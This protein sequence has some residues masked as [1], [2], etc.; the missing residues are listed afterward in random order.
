MKVHK[1]S[2]SILEKAYTYQKTMIMAKNKLKKRLKKFLIDRKE[3]QIKPKK[4]PL[5]CLSRI[6]SA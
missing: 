1:W 5:K 6:L 2:K 3:R 4:G